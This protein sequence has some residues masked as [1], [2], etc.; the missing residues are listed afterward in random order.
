M[1]TKHDQRFVSEELCNALVT[2][3]TQCGGS[4]SVIFTRI[5]GQKITSAEMESWQTAL[6]MK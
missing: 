2:T 3:P 1:N 5:I 6:Q 4:F